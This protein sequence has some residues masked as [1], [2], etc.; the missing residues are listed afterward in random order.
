MIGTK[1]TAD[2]ASEDANTTVGSV[3]GS[4][5]DNVTIQANDTVQLKKA[6]VLA[7]NDIA[8]SGSDV[9]LAGDTNTR[10]STTLHEVKTSGLTVALSGTV[11]SAV[12]TAI[13]L[14]KPCKG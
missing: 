4:T 2:A 12:N 9:T 8:I 1:K 10:T 11:M 14:K 5:E 3:I 7:K 13:D 6:D